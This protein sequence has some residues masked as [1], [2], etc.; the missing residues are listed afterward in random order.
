MTDMR[1]SES[2]RHFA[3]G[4]AALMLV[5]C[6]MLALV[7]QELLTPNQLTEAIETVISVKRQ[8]SGDTEHPTVSNAAIALLSGIANSV[9][10]TPAVG[11]DRRL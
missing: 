8:S 5:E 4:E 7:E 2:E 9:S 1:P 11:I 10:A 6:L 3:E